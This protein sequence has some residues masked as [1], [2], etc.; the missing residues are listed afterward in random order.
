MAIKENRELPQ[1][2]R[3]AGLPSVDFTFNL[4]GWSQVA[5]K[6]GT[7]K[8]SSAAEDGARGVKG[9]LKLLPERVTGLVSVIVL[10]LGPQW[11]LLT[12]EMIQSGWE[13]PIDLLL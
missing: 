8:L 7:R 2:R 13:G 4:A 3:F 9:C 5:R 12:I 11:F 10:L 6:S 1:C